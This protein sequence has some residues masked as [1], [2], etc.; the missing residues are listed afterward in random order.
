MN[1]ALISAG[2]AAFYAAAGYAV[3]RWHD[4]AY[5]TPRWWRLLLSRTRRSFRRGRARATRVGNSARFAVH[6]ARASA[7][8]TVR[9]AR[10][11]AALA[12][13]CLRLHF[14]A[15]PAREVDAR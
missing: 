2:V 1:A 11:R 10:S 4:R 7:V 14:A 8:R 13:Y 12:A 5:L 9:F 6:S 15:L 3:V